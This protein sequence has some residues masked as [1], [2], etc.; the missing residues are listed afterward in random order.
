[1]LLSACGGGTPPASPS[2]TGAPATTSEAA[3]LASVSA[4]PVYVPQY[5]L[6]GRLVESVPGLQAEPLTLVGAPHG[7]KVALFTNER[8]SAKT[9]AVTI[10]VCSVA[11]AV[12]GCRNTAALKGSTE[13]F[14]QWALVIDDTGKLVSAKRTAGSLA[15][16]ALEKCMEGAIAGAKFAQEARG[17]TSVFI[18]TQTTAAV[19]IMVETGTDIAG[20]LPPERIKAVVRKSFPSFRQCF[21]TMAKGKP[22][23]EQL[24]SIRFVID[25]GG[26]PTQVE[27]AAPDPTFRACV[28]TVASGLAFPEPEYGKVLVTYPIRFLNDL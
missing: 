28:A 10:G 25:E 11:E 15:D 21:E 13:G 6:D 2:P 24:A 14:V 16:E 17:E 23:T 26:K 9:E 1:M 5:C 27:V 18:V 19:V 22:F 20:R 12:R 8:A 7:G 4:A 3:T